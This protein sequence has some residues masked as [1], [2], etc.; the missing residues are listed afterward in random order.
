MVKDETKIIELKHATIEVAK[1]DV[2]AKISTKPAI[3][4]LSIDII[5]NR[6][7][8]FSKHGTLIELDPEIAK[9]VEAALEAIVRTDI[10]VDQ[11]DIYYSL[12]MGHPDWK[13]A[14]HELKTEEAYNTFTGAIMEKLQLWTGYTMQSLGVRAGP[15]GFITGDQKTYFLLPSGQQIPVAASP[16]IKFN[17]VDEGVQLKT[18]ARKLIHYE[19]SAGMDSLTIND[20]STMIE[21]L[22]MTSQGYCVEAATKMHADMEKRGLR[23][24]VLG[25]ADPHGISIQLMY[26]RASQSN[27]YMPDAFYPKKA[28][29][30]GLFPRIA[31]ALNLPAEHV[32][33]VHMRVVPNL[34]KLMQETRPEMLPDAEVFEK[35]REQWEWQSL[36]GIDQYAPAIY[37]IEALRARNDEIKY[38]PDSLT[39]KDVLKETIHQLVE[40]EVNDQIEK[41][42]RDWLMENLK[43]DFVTQLKT[44]LADQIRQFE[45]DAERELGKLDGMNQDDL[46]EAVKLKLVKNPKQYYTDAIRKVIA[47]ILSQ[48]FIV[49]AEVSGEVEVDRASV[50]QNVTISNPEVPPQPLTKDDI[51][52]AIESKITRKQPLIQRL[53]QAIETVLGQPSQNW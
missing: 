26:C 9:I 11:R 4:R 50:D 35:Y 12:R 16:V 5:N 1:P 21:A 36:N 3:P 52:E 6:W 7:R 8:A 34:K 40:E 46:R 53:R 32:G 48:R 14:G 33:D 38:V 15:R 19:K 30:L 29:L 51:V 10:I 17:L 24:F 25:D 49:N 37:M 41:Y 18:Q 45:A 13:L 31:R 28:T 42:A 23:L 47:D 39:I 44:Y 2:K 27:A 43:E 22:F 20:M